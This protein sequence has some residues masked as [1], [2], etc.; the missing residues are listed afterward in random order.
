MLRFLHLVIETALSICEVYL[1]KR[2][3]FLHIFGHF[4]LSLVSMR[5]TLQ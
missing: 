5:M 2:G 3:L 4:R 1:V